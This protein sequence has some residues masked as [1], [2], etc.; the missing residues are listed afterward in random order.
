[1]TTLENR[2]HTALIV[3]D[4]QNGVVEGDHERDAVL[5]NI[6]GLVERARR[7]RVP[8]IWVQ[9]STSTLLPEAQFSG[10]ALKSASTVA[11]AGLGLPE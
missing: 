8:V 7:E 6:A 9:H 5:A 11:A 10:R 4:V 3:I 1:M 2:P